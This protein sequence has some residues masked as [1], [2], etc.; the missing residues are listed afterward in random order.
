MR[1][2]FVFHRLLNMIHCVFPS[3]FFFL[4]LTAV[5]FRFFSFDSHCC[6]F[7]ALLT[8]FSLLLALLILVPEF[9][10]VPRAPADFEPFDVPMSELVK[11]KR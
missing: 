9:R 7:F 11:R 10:Q 1:K 5:C 8:L 2:S 3:L 6:V 4:I